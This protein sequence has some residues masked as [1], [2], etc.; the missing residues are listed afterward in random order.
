LASSKVLPTTGGLF[1]DPSVSTASRVLPRFQ[2]GLILSK[3]DPADI[4]LK[5]VVEGHFTA[6][7]FPVLLPGFVQ[8]WSQYMIIE[9]K[10]ETHTLS[11]GTLEERHS[12]HCSLC[13]ATHDRRICMTS[14]V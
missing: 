4:G 1:H 11:N 5:D 3:N 8:H 7:P 9:L 10:R 2:P 6:V 12:K 13:E 14:E